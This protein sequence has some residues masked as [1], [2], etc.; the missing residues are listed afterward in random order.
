MS[1][2][3]TLAAVG[4]APEGVTYTVRPDGT[5]LLEG[6]SDGLQLRLASTDSVAP[7]LGNSFEVLSRREV[8]P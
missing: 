8:K 3:A 7:F 1:S 2:P 4:V 5:F 6:V